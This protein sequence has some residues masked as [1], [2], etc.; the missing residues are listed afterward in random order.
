V[1]CQAVEIADPEERRQFLDQACGT[2][3]ALREQVEGLLALSQSS[4]DFYKRCAPALEAAPIDI[5]HSF[6][7]GRIVDRG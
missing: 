1:F 4:G 3:K 7:G 6:F 5:D 2:D